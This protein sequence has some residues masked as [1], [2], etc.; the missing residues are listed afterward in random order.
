MGRECH[1]QHDYHQHQEGYRCRDLDWRYGYYQTALM[2]QQRDHPHHL[3]PSPSWAGHNWLRLD[4]SS[5]LKFLNG[6]HH[7]NKSK[8]YKKSRRCKKQEG[9]EKEEEGGG[10]TLAGAPS[11]PR[12]SSHH[13]DEA[14]EKKSR[15]GEG[16][17]SREE[18]STI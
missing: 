17:K 11:H 12:K 10:A 3:W 1:Y 6:L 7:K 18:K 4:P 2:H 5:T 15:V 13:R 14:R 8:N 16:E 9:E